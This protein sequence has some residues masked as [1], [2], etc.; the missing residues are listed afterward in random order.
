MCES[1]EVEVLTTRHG[2]RRGLVR[3]SAVVR[4]ARLLSANQRRV[5][6]ITDLQLDIG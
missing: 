5:L 4:E 3:A 1:T 2:D 6:G